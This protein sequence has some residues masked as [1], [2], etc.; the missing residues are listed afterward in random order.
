[1]LMLLAL[2]GM[3]AGNITTQEK[4]EDGDGDNFESDH[5]RDHDDVDADDINFKGT[6]TG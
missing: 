2:V 3:V 5:N 1:M 4:I 6:P